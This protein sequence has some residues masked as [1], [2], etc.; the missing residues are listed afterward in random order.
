MVLVMSILMLYYYCMQNIFAGKKAV[1]VGGSGGIGRAVSS[2]FSREGATVLSIGRHPASVNSGIESRILDLDDPAN[3]DVVMDVVRGCDILCVVRGPFLQKSLADT[4]AD[5]WTSI[6]YANL[7]F[8]G[9]LV[10]AAL[11][12]MCANRW[13]R[14]LLFGG[15][16]TDAI[17]G[18]KTNA[19][20]AA[21]KTGLS[22]LVKSVALSYAGSGVVCNALC[23]GFTDTEYIGSERK[24]SLSKKSPDGKLLLIEEIAETAFFLTKNANF[25]GVAVPFDKGWAPEFI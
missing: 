1:V 24:I 19:A 2:V 6:V 11:P 13:G 8:P 9:L 5:E 10:S 20:Y 4:N 16:R 21:A 3:R 14:I 25:N 15:T 18:F 22:S 7:T 17:R 23:P 12:R